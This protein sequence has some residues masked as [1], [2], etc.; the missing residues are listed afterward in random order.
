MEALCQCYT[1][2]ARQHNALGITERLPE[3]AVQFFNRPFQ[4]IPAERFVQALL[5]QIT[6][7]QLLAVS[8]LGLIGSID[9]FSDNTDLRSY[10]AWRLRLRRLFE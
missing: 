10:P 6:D 5:A 4:V 1:H 8:R 2:L 3:S 9:L 7:P